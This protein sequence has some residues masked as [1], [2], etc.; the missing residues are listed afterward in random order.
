MNLSFAQTYN[1][2]HQGLYPESNGIVDNSMFDVELNEKFYLGA[3]ATMMPEWWL[4]EPVSVM[5][6]QHR[7]SVI[8]LGYRCSSV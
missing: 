2:F 4:G 3:P 5:S 7:R 1:F 8:F 6:L